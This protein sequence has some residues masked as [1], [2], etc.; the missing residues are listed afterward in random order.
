MTKLHRLVPEGIRLVST[1]FLTDDIPE[2][3]PEEYGEFVEPIGR[4][5]SLDEFDRVINRV[6]DQNEP[7]TTS[8][9]RDA[10]PLVHESLPLTRREA[11]DMGIWQYLTIIHRPDFVRYRWEYSTLP[12]RRRRF[13]GRHWRWDSNAIGRLWWIAEQTVTEHGEY[14]LTATLLKT[15]DFARAIFSRD[16]GKYL[17]AVQAATVV[18]QNQSDL[19]IREVIKRFNRRLSIVHLESHDQAE[20]EE[21]LVEILSNVEYEQ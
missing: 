2:L 21:I 1:E 3:H 10:A 9:D 6:I 4:N 16:I 12:E 15:Q 13:V 11:A 20:I 7:F 14:E 8:I 19:T 18:L 5:I 17:P